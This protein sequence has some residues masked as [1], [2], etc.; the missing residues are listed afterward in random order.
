VAAGERSVLTRLFAIRF[1]RTRTILAKT[2]VHGASASIPMP[3][4][5]GKI[6]SWIRDVPSRQS[7]LALLRDRGVMHAAT[8]KTT[9]TECHFTECA[10]C[11]VEQ[12]S[13][14]GTSRL[15]LINVAQAAPA[16]ACKRYLVYPAREEKLEAKHMC[17]QLLV[18]GKS[19][20]VTTQCSSGNHRSMTFESNVDRACVGVRIR[21]A[22]RYTHFI[23]NARQRL[24]PKHD[25]HMLSHA[26]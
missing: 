20:S 25:Y 24:R 26:G 21:I 18:A 7:P 2:Y 11:D 22:L 19:I 14:T 4:I 15:H 6:S 16:V 17:I 13:G 9:S 10:E 1:C 5:C 8:S 3:T 23:V 12:A